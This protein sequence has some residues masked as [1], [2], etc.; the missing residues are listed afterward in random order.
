VPPL[1]VVTTAGAV[2]A[3]SARHPAP[4]RCHRRVFTAPGA[5]QRRSKTRYHRQS[6]VRRDDAGE[7]QQR[8]A[9]AAR[10]DR[11]KR[12]AL[13]GEPARGLGAVEQPVDERRER[14]RAGGAC[15]LGDLIFGLGGPGRWA[16]TPGR[17]RAEK[18]ARRGAGGRCCPRAG[19]APRC[20]PA[21]AV[22]APRRTRAA[23]C[24]PR[25][26][27]RTPAAGAPARGAPT[28]LPPH[29]SANTSRNLRAAPASPSPAGTLATYTHT[30]RNM[31]E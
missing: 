4:P 14:E 31:H 2:A 3:W 30:K 15:E 25:A 6:R 7:Q 10:D 22:G 20:A 11:A 5:A 1:A 26:V 23:P 16:P 8:H 12:G 18:M 29:V 19:R 28:W 21:A 9:D 17:G 27:S 13:A 24:C